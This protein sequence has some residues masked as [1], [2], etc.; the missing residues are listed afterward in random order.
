MKL[1]TT[2]G[3]SKS[4]KIK[5]VM[6]QSIGRV[7]LWTLIIFLFLRGVGTLFVSS[8]TGEAQRLINQFIDEKGY[9][10][11]VELEAASFAEG[12][13]IEYFTYERGGDYEERLLRYL[14]SSISLGSPGHGKIRAL[15]SRGY[16]VEW[17]SG[18]QLNVSVAV[19]VL[20][21]IQ[22]QENNETKTQSKEDEV[23]IVVPVMELEGKYIVEDHPSIV[24]APTKAEVSTIF[25]SGAGPD[26]AVVN[27]IKEVLESFF[28]TYYSGSPGE[29][30]YYMHE[31][32]R[33]SGLEGRYQLNRLENVRV[34]DIGIQDEHLVIAEL[35]ITD[36]MSGILYK[37]GYHIQLIKVNNRYY[38]KDFS[39]RTVN[40]NN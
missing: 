17:F 37:Q 13:A 29:I 22:L 39:V 34:Y 5:T 20:Y 18:N 26:S 40:I 27:E 30:S 32:K 28:K 33:V 10:E 9:K 24:P 38:I 31:N 12:F 7:I 4:F 19:K 1:I 21:E 25:Y 15:N 23:Y 16:S 35:T 8:E 2:K 14:P 3:K 36:S 11:R 6:F